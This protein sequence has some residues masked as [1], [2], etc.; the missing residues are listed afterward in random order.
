[1]SASLVKLSAPPSPQEIEVEVSPAALEQLIKLRKSTGQENMDF[2]LGVQGG[3][4]SGFT[5][6]MAFDQRREGDIVVA[7]IG[8]LSVIVDPV[9]APLLNHVTI[10]FALS[11]EESGFKIRNPNAHEVCSC[12]KSFG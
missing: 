8:G 7:K 9:S 11:L 6:K 2:R 12:G 10:D 3:G 5:Y 4:C 1:M